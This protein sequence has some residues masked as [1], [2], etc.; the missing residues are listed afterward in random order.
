[1]VS[2]LDGT[3]QLFDRVRL[4]SLGGVFCREL[5]VHKDQEEVAE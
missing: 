4:V 1:L 2:F 3:D 5:E